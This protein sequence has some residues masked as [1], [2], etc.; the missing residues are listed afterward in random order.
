VA[1]REQTELRRTVGEPIEQTFS[2]SEFA[3]HVEFLTPD[4]HVTQVKA[5]PAAVPPEPPAEADP[6]ALVPLS[7]TF[8]NTDVPGVYTVRLVTGAGQ[9]Q[10]QQIAF[11]VPAAE[12]DLRIVTDAELRA[13]LGP[14]RNLTI[15]PA[16]A[17][18]WIRS[19]APGEDVRRG[20]LML[21]VVIIIA[22]Q[23]LA[24]RLSYHPAVRRRAPAP[25]V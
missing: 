21:L 17:F 16:G 2:R 3:D 8:R 4:G 7:A 20:I 19:E 10:D 9:L 18:E 6:R 12:G 11:N 15:Q 14:V 22:E 25:A 24:Y 13:G 23:A 5:V 1:R